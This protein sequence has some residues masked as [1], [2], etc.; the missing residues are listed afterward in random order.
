VTACTLSGHADERSSALLTAMM[1]GMPLDVDDDTRERVR[2]HY[3]WCTDVLRA[4]DLDGF[5]NWLG[6]E[7]TFPAQDGSTVRVADTRPF[8]SWRF[9]L[10]LEVRRCDIVVN[11][12][13]WRAD[14]LLAVDFHERS[15]LTVKGYDGQPVERDADLQNRNLWE[16]D[17][18]SFTTRGG[19][20]ISA[21]RTLDGQP[22]TE[23][24]DPWGFEAWRRFRDSRPE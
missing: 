22:L 1:G 23:E 24:L 14:G 6:P 3:R 2:R 4:R 8:W 19:E 20:E 16:V 10:V 15:D 13:A 5:L 9:S 17:E 12:I 7:G 11:D 21:H 18:A